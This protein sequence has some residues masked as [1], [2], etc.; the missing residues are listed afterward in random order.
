[1]RD[2]TQSGLRMLGKCEQLY[3]FR[4][5]E[6]LRARGGRVPLDIGS[7]VHHGIEVSSAEAA[8]DFLRE[9]A[10]AAWT[11]EEKR[12]I[13]T[14]AV[15]VFAMVSGALHLWKEWPSEREVQFRIPLKNPRTGRSSRAHSFGGKIDGLSPG[16]VWEFKTASS[17]DAS[18]VDRLEIDYQVSAYMEAAS[19][20]QGQPVR[21]ATYRVIKKP[22]IR[23]RQK[24]SIVEF[25]ERIV[26]D[27]RSRPEFYFLEEL[28]TRSE[29]Q[30]TLWRQEAWEIHKRILALEAGKLAIRNTES[31]VGRFGRCRFLDLCCGALDRGSFAVEEKLHP[32]LD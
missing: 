26:S 20:L 22:G 19:V 18:Y 27:Y 14:T 16:R 9:S 23:K 2:I 25:R 3:S 28:L 5:I 6:R 4:K 32:E 12:T 8:A 24:E 13:E 30:M 15:T 10:E 17:I 7:A 29:A 11:S 21:H 1:M 31:C